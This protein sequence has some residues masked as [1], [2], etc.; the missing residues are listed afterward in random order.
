MNDF[1]KATGRPPSDAESRSYIIG[2]STERRLAIYRHL[3]QA[4]L[5]GEGPTTPG[6][7][8]APR[9]AFEMTPL[10][11]GAAIVAMLVIIALAVHSGAVTLAK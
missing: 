11:W 8:T 6:S 10:L 9:A 2:E 1:I 3:A 4:T 7:R 5:S